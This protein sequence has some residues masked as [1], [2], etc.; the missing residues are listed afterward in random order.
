MPGEQAERSI[1][2]ARERGVP[3]SPPTVQKLGETA[4]RLGLVMP[5]AL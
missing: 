4:G 1:A 5:A 2:A 3:L